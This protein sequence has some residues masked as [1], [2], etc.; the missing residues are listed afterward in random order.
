MKHVLLGAAALAALCT[1]P[2]AAQSVAIT[3]A[4]LVIGDG[5]A[6]IDGGTV[7][8]RGGRV[9]AAGKSV[10]VPAG[11]DTVDAGGRYVTPGIVAGFTR[12]GLV[13]VDAVNQTNDVNAAG[14]PFHAAIDVVPGINP[15]VSAIT[16]N[17][18]EGITRAVVAPDTAGSVF[19][20][21]GAVIDLGT[22]MQP[23]TRAR[24]FQF[25]EYGE[26]GAERA[27]GSRP[28]AIAM[29]RNALKQA[30][31]FARSPA[32]YADQGKN[33][34]LNRADA[35]ALAPVADGRIPLFIH[36]ERAADMLT[37]IDLKRE[38]PALSMVFIGA[39]EGWLV[40]PQLATARVPVIASALNDLPESFEALAA[41]QSNI[42]RMKAAGVLVG[43]GM[44]NDNDARQA[45]LE[46]QYAG[47]LVALGR[48]P[49]ATGMRWDDA[50]AAITS[51]PAE[52]IGIGGDIGSLRPGRRGDVVIWSGDPLELD[53]A[54]LAVY[55]DG[56]KQPLATRQAELLKRY[57]QPQE[58]ALP[59]AYER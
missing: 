54:A 44:I 32:A 25:M 37:L 59:K 57:I 4:K 52:S 55:I 24:A 42:G 18:A 31:D 34:L 43:I 19:T 28:A 45:R 17:R 53:T 58:G 1:T 27:G 50:F 33:A 36:V 20:G 48:V 21:M 15:R 49:G 56:V 40:A 9:V 7:I 2:A 47:N 3:N 35:E 46:K 13:E 22:D 38:M 41:T 39:S 14:S 16:L 30:R 5:S 23:I 8:V 6:P 51:V 10:T 29:F 12:V 26:G 11:I